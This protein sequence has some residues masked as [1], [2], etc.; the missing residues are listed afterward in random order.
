MGFREAGVVMR[1]P[2]LLLNGD[3]EYCVAIAASWAWTAVEILRSWVLII[4]FARR[5]R[6][7]V[8]GRA[9]R[10]IG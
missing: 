7:Y 1:Y 2:W 9:Q 4:G 5:E 6:S 10:P 3:Q 8:Q